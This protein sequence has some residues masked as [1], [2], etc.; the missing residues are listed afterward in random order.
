L[1]ELVERLILIE[2]VETGLTQVKE[3]EVLSS[4]EVEKEM[5]KW[6]K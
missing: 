1:D 5:A 3:G 2:K 6:F 4:N